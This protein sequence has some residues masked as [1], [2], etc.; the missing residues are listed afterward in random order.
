MAG[1]DRFQCWSS[2]TKRDQG[3]RGGNS[4]TY[5]KK[6]KILCGLQYPP[7]AKRVHGSEKERK[8]GEGG[9]HREGTGKEEEKYTGEAAWTTEGEGWRGK[10]V[11]E[12]GS[13][14]RT[15]R[16]PSASARGVPCPRT[17]LP[18][19][20]PCLSVG[21]GRPERARSSR[22]FT[23]G[24]GRRGGA[25]APGREPSR[26]PRAGGTPLRRAGAGAWGPPLPPP[27]RRRRL[28]PPPPA[29]PTRTPA[30]VKPKPS[31][32][33]QERQQPAGRRGIAWGAAS[34]RLARIST[35]D[36]TAASPRTQ[37]PAG[38]PALRCPGPRRPR[39][40]HGQRPGPHFAAASPPA[41]GAADSRLAQ[42]LSR[43]QR[44]APPEHGHRG[45]GA[46]TWQCPTA[47]GTDPL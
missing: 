10:G 42:P 22:R 12:E 7:L 16:G 30:A 25:S 28:P 40:H 15:S 39:Q 8:G 46:S 5:L 27:G 6:R 18:L 9:E 3:T 38:P 21:P 1:K 13:R 36:S 47:A 45:R 4:G 34:P 31:R 32:C 24:K 11:G 23:R 43:L 17:V 14:G 44:P 29:V 33:L 26:W 37:E 20:P 41:D 35:A 19:S 2:L